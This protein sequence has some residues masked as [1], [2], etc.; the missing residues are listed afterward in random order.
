MTINPYPLRIDPRVD[1]SLR[2][3]MHRLVEHNA[4]PYFNWLMSA[5]GVNNATTALNEAQLHRLSQ[6]GAIPAQDLAKLQETNFKRRPV[7]LDHR[8]TLAMVE[9]HVSRLCLPCMRADPYHRH[10]WD[11]TPLTRCPEHGTPLLS[12]CPTCHSPLHWRR[13]ELAKCPARDNLLDPEL[14]K[15]FQRSE[16]GDLS[17]IRAVHEFLKKQKT[18]QYIS[19]IAMFADLT[20]LDLVAMLDV[21]GRISEPTGKVPRMGTKLRYEAG[22]YH[23]VLNRG[24]AIACDWP[25][26][27][28]QALDHRAKFEERRRFLTDSS[29][30]FRRLLQI[31]LT[32]NSERPYARAISMALWQ[33]AEGN[34][35]VLAPGA[36]GYTPQDFHERYITASE[37][38]NLVKVDLPK[39]SRI[40]KQAGW[41]GSDQMLTGRSA[42]LKQSEVHDWLARKQKQISPDVLEKLLRVRRPTIFAI[43]ERGLFG[44][45]AAGRLSSDSL[46]R[47]A[48]PEYLDFIN[49]LRGIRL[50]SEPDHSTD[51]VT[52][53]SFKKRPESKNI[54][55][56]DL[57]AGVLD[58]RVRVSHIDETSLSAIRFNLLDVVSLAMGASE[59]REPAQSASS[60]SPAMSL[61]TAV[62]RYKICWYRLERAIDMGLLV[63]DRR[64]FGVTKTLVTEHA[65][66]VFLEKFTSTTR[67]AYMHSKS[68]GSLSRI[69]VRFGV[70]PYRPNHGVHRDKLLYAW[71][72][73]D[74]VG[75]K[76]IIAAAKKRR[77]RKRPRS[78]R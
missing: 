3:Y 52:W 40:A 32:H 59:G 50:K 63:A 25:Q 38:R 66:H 1:E 20:L 67:L 49:R 17:G 11:F 56:A 24:Y 69:F 53:T 15:S 43:A 35:I 75:L 18:G 62:R 41:F 65:M 71:K 73:I 76:K 29:L 72:D 12:K 28:H 36:F 23:L 14:D 16:P 44:T 57:I 39:L 10:A 78:C 77:P 55:F 4:L 54:S 19:K 48:E 64:G 60:I 9:R 21:L 6:I 45:D 47:L 5:L 31:H 74:V 61:R 30:T 13:N 42:W 46:W 68:S 34:G 27:F 33:Y 58:A 37:A 7:L 70:K 26:A 51:Y 8:V 2:S 22:D